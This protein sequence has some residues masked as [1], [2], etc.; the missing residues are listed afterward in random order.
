MNRFIDQMG[1]EV[2]LKDTPK[3]IVSIVPSQTELL[4][5]LGLQDEV[6][7]ITKFCVHPKSW[8]TTKKRVGG[9]KNVN[10]SSVKELNPDLIIANKEENTLEDIQLLE[11]I[12]PVWISDINSFDDAIEMIYQIGIL[13]DKEIEGKSLIREILDSFDDTN[14]IES[15]NSAIYFIWKQPFMCAG[16]DTFIDAMMTKIGLKNVIQTERYPVLEAPFNLSFK[17]DW[18]LLSSEPYP[19]NDAHVEEMKKYFPESKIIIVDGEFFSWY[20]SRMRFAKDYF[21]NV[22]SS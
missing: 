12:A 7:G 15:G 2:L 18:V 5:D 13:V 10:I 1:R 20:G 14:L 8:Y 4:F 21:I 16:I 17:P 11:Q 6:V 19:F 22:F 3:R 9:T